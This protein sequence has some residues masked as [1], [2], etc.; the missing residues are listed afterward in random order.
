[1]PHPFKVQSVLG[2]VSTDARLSIITATDPGGLFVQQPVRYTVLDGETQPPTPQ[3]P[4]PAVNDLDLTFMDSGFND[5]TNPWIP[6][7]EITVNGWDWTMP[8][9][10]VPHP[11]SGIFQNSN[12]DT[13][14]YL[15]GFE[16]NKVNAD[17]VDLEPSEGNFDMTIIE[18]GLADNNFDGVMLN[19]RGTVVSIHD[20]DSG[21][22]VFESSWSAPSWLQS[23]TYPPE[24][25]ASNGRYLNLLISSSRVDNAMRALI[26][27]IGGQFAD[28]PKLFFQII[29][30]VSDTRGEEWTGS[31]ANTQTAIDAMEGWI[32]DWAANYGADADKLMWLKENP[33]QLWNA[34]VSAG[35]GTRG[36][37]IETWLNNRYTTS[38]PDETSQELDAVTGYLTTNEDTFD[39]ISENRGW[40]DQNEAYRGSGS[41]EPQSTW[42]QNYLMANLRCAQM[43]R[44][45][46]WVADDMRINPRLDNWLSLQ[47]GY[48]RNDS[49][50]AWVRLMRS[51]SRG[52]S[53][54]GF[55]THNVNNFERYLLQREVNGSTTPTLTR[56]HGTNA[57]PRNISGATSLPQNFWNISWG[58]KTNSM[59][60]S[61]D[62]GWM[63]GGPHDVY[64][65]VVWYDNTPNTWFL[66]YTPD[67]G[68][69]TTL[70]RK[71]QGD[72]TIRTT[73][74]RIQDFTAPA[75]G[76]NTDFT[77]RS[78]NNQ[79]F[80]FIEIIK[81]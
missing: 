40:Q 47:C 37:S 57:E 4:L 12:G 9:N 68:G 2:G 46:V 76:E 81:A 79:V 71:G 55:G 27:E 33:F 49:R 41:P 69:I 18:D 20:Q 23:P 67:G 25:G 54:E 7:D 14:A 36:G 58:R 13:P 39:I 6:D 78:D 35:C 11:R 17:W 70:S 60:I 16:L 43:L 59:G 45:N 31:Q 77:I 63:T 73:K 8:P 30:G 66:D 19:V 56:Q 75:S 15:Q 29:H 38:D 5:P 34:A 28:H 74:W 26:N 50:T 61:I 53:T 24:D 62:P 48:H 65:R 44:N 51:Y 3:P 42:Q 52:N 1:M 80:I 22:P 10:S 64:V 32:D 72:N 21:D